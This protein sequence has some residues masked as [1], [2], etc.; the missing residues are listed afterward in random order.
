[1]MGHVI[2]YAERHLFLLG[3]S[4]QSAHVLTHSNL[5]LVQLFSNTPMGR[6]SPKNCKWNLDVPSERL[7]KSA[8]GGFFIASLKWGIPDVCDVSADTTTARRMAG[9]DA[10][11]NRLPSKP[12]VA[13]MMMI[14][15]RGI[16]T[17]GSL[18]TSLLC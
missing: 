9:H 6:I 13:L 15:T 4:H 18:E 5:L 12:N 8:P 7:S 1:M 14:P 2:P 11:Q 10:F 3:S 17:D 16:C